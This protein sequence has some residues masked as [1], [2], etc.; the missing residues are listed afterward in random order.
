MKLNK[1]QL[2]ILNKKLGKYILKKR[3]TI[4]RH[5]KWLSMDNV[6]EFPNF[7]R[8]VFMLNG[9]IIPII[10]IYCENCGLQIP[11]NAIILGIVEKDK[12]RKKAKKKV[13]KKKWLNT[14]KKKLK[15]GKEK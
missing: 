1:E 8:D 2:D 15:G 7:D 4:C 11:F 12:L 3:C 5:K 14:S 6:F 9:R 13:K 10:I